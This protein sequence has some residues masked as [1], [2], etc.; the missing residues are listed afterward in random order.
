M[1]WVVGEGGGEGEEAD[2]VFTKTPLFYLSQISSEYLFVPFWN[3]M[4]N[5]SGTPCRWLSV[6]VPNK[7][8]PNLNFSLVI[9]WN[10]ITDRWSLLIYILQET[11]PVETTWVAACWTMRGSVLR[12]LNNNNNNNNNNNDNNNNNN[13][14]I[15]INN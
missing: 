13:K 10:A 1:G 7:G 9:S 11:I 5:L 8:S 4:V 14:V 3:F 15:I 2:G 12:D 6:L